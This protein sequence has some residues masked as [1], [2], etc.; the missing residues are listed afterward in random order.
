MRSVTWQA[1]DPNDDDL[2][3]DVYFR[4]VDEKSWKMIRSRVDEDFVTLDSAAMPDGTYLVRV[5]ASDAPSN[6]SGQA[7]TAEKL[8][9]RFDVDNTPPRVEGV[10]VQVLPKGANLSFSVSD[11]FSIVREAA[12]AVD[13]GDWVA[14]RPEDG[15]NDAQTE[16]YSVTLPSLAPGEHSIVVRATDAAGNVG[17]GKTVIEAP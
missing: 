12:Y 4:A 13:A 11:S 10:K 2:V 7:L 1:T 16:R 14:A 3:Y 8:S 5:V 15:L 6:P 17:A 9:E